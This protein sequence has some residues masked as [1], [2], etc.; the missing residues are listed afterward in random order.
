MNDVTRFAHFNEFRNGIRGSRTHLI[1]GIDIAK[2]KHHAFFGTAYGQTLWRRLI[3]TNA[4]IGYSAQ[5]DSADW[6]RWQ[7]AISCLNQANTDSDNIRH[8]VEWVLLCSAFEHLLSAKSNAKDVACKLAETFASPEE[9]L[10]KDAT[11]CSCQQK[12]D[13]CSVRYQW[14]REFYR[15]RGDF[16][17]GKLN[18]QQPTTW[19]HL[20]H[21][22]LATIAFTLLV[23]S[24][25]DKACK[26]K[27]TD[28]D[29]AQIDIFEK[30]A[31]SPDF[32]RPPPG[33]RDTLDSHSKRFVSERVSKI[34]SAKA[35]NQAWNNLTPEQRR[36]LGGSPDEEHE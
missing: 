8:Q 3:F 23:K 21:L 20:E 10:A 32:L 2:D 16:A 33:Q 17:H 19:N 15:I 24:L 5:P 4:L 11:R 14:M 6:G 31:D 1:V 12:R 26:Y 25:L 13:G 34:A 9:L 30:F 22:V 27:L 18:T 28:N 35:F 36:C 7:N 29:R